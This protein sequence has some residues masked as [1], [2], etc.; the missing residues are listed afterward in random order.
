M[1][2]QT[3]F[4]KDRLALPHDSMT[5]DTKIYPYPMP[6]PQ[7]AANREG[8]GSLGSAL[9]EAKSKAPAHEPKKRTIFRPSKK[10]I[11]KL[12][13]QTSI[14]DFCRIDKASDEPHPDADQEKK[15]E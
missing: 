3:R 2:L 12:A 13:G 14:F 1:D 7:P 6:P 10:A 9:L 5:T 8:W 4:R 15:I 11:P